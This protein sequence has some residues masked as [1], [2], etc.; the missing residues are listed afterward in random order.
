MLIFNISQP[1]GFGTRSTHISFPCSTK[2]SKSK[3]YKVPQALREY[4]TRN[5][6]FQIICLKL[7][8]TFRK[9]WNLKNSVA[10]GKSVVLYN[11]TARVFD[12]FIF[13]YMTIVYELKAI[14]NY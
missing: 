1:L 6:A 10:H 5:V 4:G 2:C 3:N 14:I 7:R 8:P 11:N 9:Y 12:T 13:T